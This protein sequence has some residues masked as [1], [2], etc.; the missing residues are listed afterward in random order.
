MTAVLTSKENANVNKRIFDDALENHFVKRR[1]KEEISLKKKYEDATEDY[2]VA[3][4]F[5]E[6]YH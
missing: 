1:R 6:Q 3:I 2:I 4:Y 5:H